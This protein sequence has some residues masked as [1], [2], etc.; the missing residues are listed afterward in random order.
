MRRLQCPYH[1]W[2][3]RLRRRAAQRAVH[4]RASRTSTRRATGL[5]PVRLAVVEGLVLLD[6]SGDGAAAG[7]ARRRPAG[8]ARPLPARRPAPRRPRSSTTSTRTGRRSPRTTASACTARACTPSSTASRTTSPASPS[9][10]AGAW[11]GG[12]MTLTRGRGDDGQG[13]RPGGRPPIEGLTEH[14][15]RTVLYFLAVPEH[16]RVAAPGLRDA[17]HAVA[18]RRRPHRGRLRVVLRAG[19]DRDRGLRRRPTRSTSGTRSTARTGRSA[20]SRSA[21]IGNR[22]YSAGRYTDQ[23]DDVHA[24]DVMVADRYLEALRRAR[25]RMTAAAGPN[26]HDAPAAA[27]STRSSSAAA[28]TA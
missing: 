23:E 5:H 4:R 22:A 21:G 11:C 13:R 14:D 26:G 8:P 2:T 3:L 16:A 18:A 17:A 12:S 6:L 7:R 20:S 24:F 10:G 9:T 15:L 19:D 1:A 27:A 25:C 28:T